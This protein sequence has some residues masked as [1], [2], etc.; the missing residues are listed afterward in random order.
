MSS[1]PALFKTVP[2]DYM[3]VY[4]DPSK[5]VSLLEFNKKDVARAARVP[6]TKTRAKRRV[7][8]RRL[9][10]LLLVVAFLPACSL[11]PA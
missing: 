7:T 9:A 8:M 3:S 5:I 10:L 4:N 6:V 11:A 1:N 2:D